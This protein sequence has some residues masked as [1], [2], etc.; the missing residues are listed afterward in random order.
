MNRFETTTT[1]HAPRAPPL[2]KI[3]PSAGR[4]TTYAVD[5]AASYDSYFGSGLYARRYPRPNPN[6]LRLVRG[7]LPSGGAV[8]DFGCGT[9]RYASPLIAAGAHVTAYNISGVALRELASRHETAVALGRLRTVKGTLDDLS[10]AIPEGTLDMALLM[11]GVLGHIRG[12]V[13][14]LNT[15]RRIVRMLRPGGHMVL[16]VPNARRR[17]GD[18]QAACAPLVACGELELGDILYQ[19]HAKKGPVGMYYHL[20]TVPQF[21]DLLDDAGLDVRAMGAESI[22]PERAVVGL[23]LAAG[24][25]VC[26]RRCHLSNFRMVSSRSRPRA[27]SHDASRG[28]RPDRLPG[29]DLVRDDGGRSASQPAGGDP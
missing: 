21:S 17:F 10:R 9:G 18:E 16:T 25:T 23:P 6:M 12:A 1:V 13:T 11:F 4:P 19:R 2:E 3:L 7:L 28:S 27:S 14:R 26:W 22:M 29:F 20:F 8:L 24:S 5:L 15:L